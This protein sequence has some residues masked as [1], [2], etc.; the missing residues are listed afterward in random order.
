M[1]RKFIATALAVLLLCGTA[2][3]IDGAYRAEDYLS[4][5]ELL[6]KQILQTY[7]G[8]EVLRSIHTLFATGIIEAYMRGGKGMYSFYLQ[9]PG[10][11]RVDIRYSESSE[12]RILNGQMAYRS[13]DNGLM[14]AVS[15]HRYLSMLYQY[16]HI[17]LPYE[18]MQEGFEA[19]ITASGV[20]DGQ[21]IK[22]LNLSYG[23]IDMDA[24]VSTKTGLIVRTTAH[25]E[26][27]GQSTSLTSVFSDFRAVGGTTLPFRIENYAR[28]TKLATTIIESYTLN[29][30]I[31]GT[32]FQ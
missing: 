5:E 30:E 29:P 27:E 10:K 4:Q 3:A 11:L 18:L 13:L 16:R 24:Y 17:D 1:I 23:D 20:M 8:P 32:L 25:F 7:G 14:E 21:P 6:I 9:R 2:F 31:S 12:I 19:R 22:V 26:V 15:A 28:N